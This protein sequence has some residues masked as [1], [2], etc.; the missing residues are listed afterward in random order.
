VLQATVE[1]QERA[2]NENILLRYDDQAFSYVD[3]VS[4]ALIERL[5]FRRAFAFDSHFE[6]F[7]PRVGT[8]LV[9]RW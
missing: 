9:N 6:V 1:D 5:R 4:F 2:E 3:A 7:R 8:L